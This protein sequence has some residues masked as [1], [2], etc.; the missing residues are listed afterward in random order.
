[1]PHKAFDINNPQIFIKTERQVTVGF[2]EQ[3]AVLFVLRQ[4]IT[5]AIDRPAL[6]KTILSMTAEQRQYKGIG[7]DLIAHLSK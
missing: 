2:P 5:D 3:K 7:K 1:L 6:L 4:S